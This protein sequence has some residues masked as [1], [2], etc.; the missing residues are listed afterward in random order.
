[1][2]TPGFLLLFLSPFLLFSQKTAYP[3]Y[4]GISSGLNVARLSHK[5]T[6]IFGLLYDDHDVHINHRESP[7][8]SFFLEVRGRGNRSGL[9]ELGY[10]FN[11]STTLDTSYIRGYVRHRT[12]QELRFNYLHVPIYTKYYFSRYRY[13]LFINYG[14][15][16]S[17]FQSGRIWREEL[18]ENANPPWTTIRNRKYPPSSVVQNRFD[19]YL[20]LGLGWQEDLWKGKVHFEWRFMLGLVDLS[21]LE[22]YSILQRNSLF[23]LGY[24]LPLKTFGELFKR[25]HE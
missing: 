9:I 16:F 20:L 7:F 10:L 13:G 19:I 8:L 6:D 25:K 24:K 22:E 4:I 17:F 23:S 3:D 18:L 1:M 14:F 21:R 12:Y 5:Q 11:G 15:G 2:K